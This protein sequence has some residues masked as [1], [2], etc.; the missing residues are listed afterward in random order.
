MDPANASLKALEFFSGI[1]AGEQA[2]KP[3]SGL[4]IITPGM[5]YLLVLVMVLA[6]NGCG[7]SS[8]DTAEDPTAP[9]F[10]PVVFIGDKNTD[11]VD[12][13][14]A[15]LDDGTDIIKLS[16]TLV[17]GGDVI[18]YAVSPDGLLVAYLADQDIDNRFELYV[19][20]ADGGT[21]LKV[22]GL[23]QANSDVC[24]GSSG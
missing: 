5:V 8:D 13:L 12:E 1:Q 16:G 18:A 2:M 11:G 24:G 10:P 22:S 9:K 19:V 3:T 21:A 6:G 17:A 4:N 14:F 15:A 7:G 23:I 20:P